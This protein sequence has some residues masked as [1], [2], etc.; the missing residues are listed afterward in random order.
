[1]K[2]LS[3]HSPLGSD[4]M[5]MFCAAICMLARAGSSPAAIQGLTSLRVRAERQ[6]FLHVPQSV[7]LRSHP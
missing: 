1:M 6:L 3:L 5:S 2:G 4:N 7:A